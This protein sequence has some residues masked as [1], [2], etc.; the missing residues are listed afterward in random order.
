MVLIFV[1]RALGYEQQQLDKAQLNLSV[2]QKQVYFKTADALPE[3]AASCC[4][5][6]I[7]DPFEGKYHRVLH[8][9]ACAGCWSAVRVHAGNKQQRQP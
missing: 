5:V 2:L 3:L 1:N 4:S 6:L 9:I 7:Q 8:I